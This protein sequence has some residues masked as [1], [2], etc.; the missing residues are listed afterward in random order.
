MKFVAIGKADRRYSQVAARIQAITDLNKELKNAFIGHQARGYALSVA[1]QCAS[2]SFAD[3]AQAVKQDKV[4]REARQAADAA[5]KRDEMTIIDCQ[6]IIE[7]GIDLL[8]DRDEWY[9]KV[10]KE[11]VDSLR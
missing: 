1:W 10:Q 11:F 7:L 2:R 8:P 5:S 6:R 9:S 3:G 4:L